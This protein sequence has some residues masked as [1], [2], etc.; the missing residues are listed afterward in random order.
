MSWVQPDAP[1]HL[2]LYTGQTFRAP[3]EESGFALDEVVYDPTAFQFW[4]REQY[5]R[6]IP[7]ADGRSYFVN[8]ENSV[9][10]AEEVA[11]SA[12]ARPSRT[13]RARATGR[14]FIRGKSEPLRG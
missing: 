13:V 6:D 1:R 8:P 10:S 14:F 9:F 4:G 11:P 7:L 3:A 2:F 5:A 12:H